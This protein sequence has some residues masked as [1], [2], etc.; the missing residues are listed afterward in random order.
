MI[1]VTKLKYDEGLGCVVN[2]MKLKRKGNAVGSITKNAN[3]IPPINNRMAMG[4]ANKPLIRELTLSAGA[5]N[6]QI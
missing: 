5:I 1:N 2:P 6:R 3:D 4:M